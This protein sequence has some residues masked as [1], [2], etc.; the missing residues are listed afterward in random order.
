MWVITIFFRLV[1]YLTKLFVVFFRSPDLNCLLGFWHLLIP[2]MNRAAISPCNLCF[3]NTYHIFR[4][5]KQF[6]AFYWYLYS[7]YFICR[8]IGLN[9]LHLGADIIVKVTIC[10]CLRTS[11]IRFTSFIFTLMVNINVLFVFECQFC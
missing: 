6:Y 7:F 8:W 5:I 9:D 1:Q 11:L 4:F 10:C 2:L 3:L